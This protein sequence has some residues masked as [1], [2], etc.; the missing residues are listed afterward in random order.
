MSEPE[1]A[2]G[3]GITHG[4]A[5]PVIDVHAH[6]YP[7]ECVA[8]VVQHCADLQV[9]QAPDGTRV[10]LWRGGV[11]HLIPPGAGDLTDRLGLMDALGIQ[12]QVLS[13]GA[14][15]VAWAGAHAP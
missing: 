6:W 1:P 2:S 8:E 15:D 12:V 13:F 3:P 10:M 7:D 11:A 14:V 4:D 9:Q 5:Q